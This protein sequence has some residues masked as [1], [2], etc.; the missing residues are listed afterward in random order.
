MAAVWLACSTHSISKPS[1][2]K[3]PNCSESNKGK[4]AKDVRSSKTK[5]KRDLSRLALAANGATLKQAAKAEQ[6]SSH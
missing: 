2:L 3:K 5:V 4:W 6:P 1:A